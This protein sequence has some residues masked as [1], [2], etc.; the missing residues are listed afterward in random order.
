MAQL[1]GLFAALKGSIIAN[2]A[3]ATIAVILVQA[4][5][6]ST[7]DATPI[8][9]TTADGYGVPLGTWT[10]EAIAEA[11]RA[12]GP[13]AIGTQPADS[14][15]AS[16]PDTRPGA[17]QDAVPASEPT[18]SGQSEQMLEAIVADAG[19]AAGPSD[20]GE[21]GIPPPPA[22]QT[23][24]ANNADNFPRTTRP[25]DPDVNGQ[26]PQA[27]PTATP[28]AGGLTP[29]ADDGETWQTPA[30][31]Q[32]AS[33]ADEFGSGGQ[34]VAPAASP[35]AT[36]R[37]TA[38]Q[39]PATPT[40]APATTPTSTTPT[41]TP[42]VSPTA[43][44]RPTSPAPTPRPSA[45]PTATPTSQPTAAPQVR[46]GGGT[47]DFEVNGASIIDP[48]GDTFVPMGFNVSAA[49]M[50]WPGWHSDV[51][52]NSSV[53]TDAWGINTL[54]LNVFCTSFCAPQGR[55]GFESIHDIIDAYEGTGVVTIVDYHAIDF[56]N[57]PTAAEKETARLYF[58]DLA[59]RYANNPYVWFGLFNEP[60]NECNF[61]KHG[62][63]IDQSRG[64]GNAT[65]T[66]KTMHETVI[67]TIRGT[68]ARNVIVLNTSNYGQDRCDAGP[69]LFD[70][71][72]SAILS[73][74][75]ELVASY[76]N[77]V[78]DMHFYSRWAAS[79]P[80]MVNDYFDAIHDAGLA[81]LVG[82][83]GG[84][85]TKGK[86]ADDDL[87]AAILLFETA[88]AGV[89][90][91]A[92]HSSFGYVLTNEGDAADINR[93]DGSRPTNLTEFGGHFWDYTR[94]LSTS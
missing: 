11:N 64:Q 25:I 17:S 58:Q 83:I 84:S 50:P 77:L 56:P 43:T 3:I 85:R 68:G 79:T 62:A 86:I 8:E 21:A 10:D 27:Q 94:A 32:G 40:T 81:V 35:A 73:F 48:Q 28:P 54:R 42:V 23:G 19:E 9:V 76:D 26:A 38:T 4:V 93:T 88:P 66:W 45:A 57:A 78:F 14:A 67:E 7:H 65:P 70:P 41:S 30:D 22:Q 59:T 72:E 80:A 69:R 33:V 61:T 2:A 60:M 13:D 55:G 90:V 52:A 89:G 15:A 53:F 34:Q 39:P 36:P 49:H 29:T 31:A 71:A 87:D 74:G 47:G 16:Q 12:S 91:I 82:E 1:S 20:G 5:V 24:G 37:P 51:V 18:A 46:Q 75:P 6:T 44:P 63:N 92:W